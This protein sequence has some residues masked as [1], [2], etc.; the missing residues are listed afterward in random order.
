MFSTRYS[1]VSKRCLATHNCV[2]LLYS[3]LSYLFRLFLEVGIQIVYSKTL[4]LY[5]FLCLH[6][7]TM[8]EHKYL[9]IINA[10]AYFWK[11]GCISPPSFSFTNEIYPTLISVTKRGREQ[12]ERGRSRYRQVGLWQ[13]DIAVIDEQLGDVSISEWHALRGFSSYNP[14]GK[15]DCP[16]LPASSG[17]SATRLGACARRKAPYTDASVVH[18]AICTIPYVLMSCHL[19]WCCRQWFALPPDAHR[20]GPLDLWPFRYAN[21]LT[22]SLVEKG[23][24]DW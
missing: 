11:D 4:D 16:Y 18:R 1:L 8:V 13:L 20:Y 6:N 12:R 19:D 22:I 23:L 21:P 7:I 3:K 9:L 2:T 24:S 17:Y 14:S 15:K 10:K 5:L